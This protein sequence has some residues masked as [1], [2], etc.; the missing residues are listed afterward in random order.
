MD[1]LAWCVIC[2]NAFAEVLLDQVLEDFAEH[3]GVNGYFLLQWL[4]LVDGEVVAVK[5]IQDTGAGNAFLD[6]IGVGEQAVGEK[7]VGFAPIIVADRLEQATIEERD[8]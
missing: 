6:G 5:H 8:T 4:S 3:F 1:D 7:D 2:A